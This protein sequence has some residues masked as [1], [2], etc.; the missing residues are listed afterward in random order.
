MGR[1]EGLV[2]CICE[3]FSSLGSCTAVD[4]SVRALTG[5]SIL[6]AEVSPAASGRFIVSIS[7]NGRP[8]FRLVDPGDCTCTRA[9]ME[10]LQSPRTI[11]VNGFSF[12]VEQVFNVI[13]S[14]RDAGASPPEVLRALVDKGVPE[15]L[16]IALV[17]AYLDFRVEG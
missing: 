10:E 6:E 2:E 17:E 4:N 3:R 7:L 1:L 12:T 13:R 15:E 11:Q 9:A 8:V 5:S 16:A 14:L